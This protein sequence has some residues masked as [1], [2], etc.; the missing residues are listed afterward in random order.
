M[1]NHISIFTFLCFLRQYQRQR[2]CSLSERELKKALRDTLTR[3]AF[4]GPSSFLLVRS[5]HAHASYPGLTLVSLARVQPLYGA[6]RKESSGTGL[7]GC[8]LVRMWTTPGVFTRANIMGHLYCFS[9]V[10]WLNRSTNNT[11]W[12]LMLQI[13][14]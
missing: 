11:K 5:E 1:I 4:L 9:S 13:K 2:K 14:S 8:R 10:V 7:K 6:G 12:L 3:A